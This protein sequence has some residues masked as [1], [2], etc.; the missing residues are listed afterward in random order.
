[1]VIQMIRGTLTAVI[2]DDVVAVL[3]SEVVNK[4]PC[5][6]CLSKFYFRHVSAVGDAI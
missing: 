3:M 4:R 1:M 6:Y 2:H 5:T